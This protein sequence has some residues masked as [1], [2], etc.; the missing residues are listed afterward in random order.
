MRYQIGVDGG[1]SKT[2]C[3]LVDARGRVAGRR[4]AAGCN[5]N[6]VGGE[7]ARRILT[8]ALQ[9]LVQPGPRGRRRAI[10]TTLLCMAG[11]RAFW[12]EFARDLRGFGRV[13]AVDDSLPVL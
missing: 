7:E 3:I 4:V 1:A 13:R 9:A 8:E 5:P 12:Q 6:A 2:E 10:A 11:S